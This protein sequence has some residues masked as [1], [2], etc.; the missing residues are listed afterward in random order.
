MM[1]NVNPLFPVM[2]SSIK[3]LKEKESGKKIVALIVTFCNNASYDQ[4]FTQVQQKT[5]EGTQVLVYACSSESIEVLTKAF[6]GEPSESFK[7][8][9]TGKK[10][11]EIASHAK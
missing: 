3:L 7:G 11:R 4:L 8:D 9:E 2:N 5:L 1:P 10:A 6:N